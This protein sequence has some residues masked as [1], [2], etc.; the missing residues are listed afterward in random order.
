[1]GAA[2]TAMPITGTGTIRTGPG[3]YKGCSIRDTSGATNTV[4]I[5]DNT[6]ASGTILFAVQLAAG[7]SAL[8][9]PG[10]GVFFKTGVFLQAGA[11]VEGSV[12]L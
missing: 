4:R 7:A 5:F 1:M 3:V 6:S 2:A 8:D 12:R 9:N 11:A 10:D